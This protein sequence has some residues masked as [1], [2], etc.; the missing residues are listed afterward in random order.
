MMELT[1]E[2]KRRIY[3]TEKERLKAQADIES[4]RLKAQ[5]EI[6]SEDQRKIL[7]LGC[8][9]VIILAMGLWLGSLASRSSKTV[10]EVPAGVHDDVSV[11]ISKYGPPDKEDT[12]ERDQPRPPIVSRW[13]D[14]EPERVRALYYAD[15]PVGTPPP[16]SHWKLAGFTD[17][18]ANV[19]LSP[20]EVVR[21]M[22]GRKR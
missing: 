10:P 20:E 2:E 7:R 12:T 17:P 19:A 6:K 22:E 9:S 16:Y 11:F 14:Y 13:L 1:P 5:A 21:R 18:V 8:L 4:E 3:E 15:V